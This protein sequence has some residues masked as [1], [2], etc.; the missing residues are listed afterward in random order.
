LTVTAGRPGRTA[1]RVTRRRIDF[2]TDAVFEF[3]FS[4][5]GKVLKRL[6]RRFTRRRAASRERP[7]RA[8]VIRNEPAWLLESPPIRPPHARVKYFILSI[9]ALEATAVKKVG[10]WSAPRVSRPREGI[11]DVG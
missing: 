9:T 7:R 1:D 10:G 8:A 6:P 5:G 2:S 11:S 3:E 4:Y